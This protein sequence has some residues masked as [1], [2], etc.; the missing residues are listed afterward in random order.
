M[1][2]LETVE[3]PGYRRSPGLCEGHLW[4]SVWPSQVPEN[5]PIFGKNRRAVAQV[6]AD[7]ASRLRPRASAMAAAIWAT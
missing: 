4:Q 6:S 1:A 7:N 3:T 2:D 5:Q